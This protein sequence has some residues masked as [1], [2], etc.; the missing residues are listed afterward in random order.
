MKFRNP[1]FVAGSAWRNILTVINNE[2]ILKT[3]TAL[4]ISKF[5]EVDYERKAEKKPWQAQEKAFY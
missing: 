5:C 1:Y 4:S 3:N 2:Y